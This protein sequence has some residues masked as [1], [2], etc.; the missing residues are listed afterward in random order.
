MLEKVVGERPGGLDGWAVG[1]MGSERAGAWD[2]CNLEGLGGGGVGDWENG[3][4]EWPS[5]VRA[6]GCENCEVG[7]LGKRWLGGERAECCVLEAWGLGPGGW[8]L[9]ALGL[10]AGS[11][12]A[13]LGGLG[14]ERARGW[15]GWG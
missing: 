7:G 2:C 14:V 11:R 15:D 10:V 4:L 3:R 13:E 5:G 9:G 1:W 6:G 12:G 8:R